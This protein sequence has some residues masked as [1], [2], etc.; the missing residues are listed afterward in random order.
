MPK[1]RVELTLREFLGSTQPFELP[2]KNVQEAQAELQSLVGEYG[3]D[4]VLLILAVQ[5][6]KAGERRVP[7]AADRHG[8]P[9]KWLDKTQMILLREA[10]VDAIENLGRQPGPMLPAMQATAEIKRPGDDLGTTPN[11]AST[12]RVA[13]NLYET[14]LVHG[15]HGLLLI[16]AGVLSHLNAAGRTVPL[17]PATYGPNADWS[18][19][20]E[21]ELTDVGIVLRH[22][23]RAL[24]CNEPFLKPSP[25]PPAETGP[26]HAP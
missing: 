9:T 2:G 19:I 12:Q 6:A 1:K 25:T 3:M 16:L 17:D 21:K 14:M 22:L 24:R 26:E 11:Y 10:L 15:L 23:A 13:D 20:T 4:Q 7:W 8:R 5:L 18:P